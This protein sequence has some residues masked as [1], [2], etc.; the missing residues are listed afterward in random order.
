MAGAIATGGAPLQPVNCTME[1]GTAINSAWYCQYCTTRPPAA[2][3]CIQNAT[4]LATQ[5]L[6][7]PVTTNSKACKPSAVLPHL[8][9]AVRIGDGPR[10]TC[11]TL[12]DFHFHLRRPV[13][14]RTLAYSPR[15]GRIRKVNV[16]NTAARNDQT[17]AALR[18]SHLGRLW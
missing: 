10:N 4:G 2:Y 14:T 9:G 12:E 1:T 15:T 5:L 8:P 16:N 13:P 18:L 11:P 17:A 7:Q 3:T 6:L